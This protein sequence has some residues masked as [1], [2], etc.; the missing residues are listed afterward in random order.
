MVSIHYALVYNYMCV[1]FECVR[2]ENMLDDISGEAMTCGT[3]L[4]ASWCVL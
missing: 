3:K 1:V 2:T 4:L